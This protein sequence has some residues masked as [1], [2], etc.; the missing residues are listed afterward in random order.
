[1]TQARPAAPG[2]PDRLPSAPGRSTRPAAWAALLVAGLWLGVVA[3]AWLEPDPRH[4]KLAGAATALAAAALG[5]GMALF[6]AAGWR[7]PAWPRSRWAGRAVV[8]LAVGAL[9]GGIWAFGHRHLGGFDHS[10]LIDVAWRVAS[11]QRPGVDFPST[12]PIGFVLAAGHAFQI[13]GVTWS[14][15]IG[16]QALF[17][18]GTFLWLLWLLRRAGSG[19]GES[20]ALALAVEASTNVVTSYWWY[21]PA[22][23]TAGAL[24]FASAAAFWREPRARPV[25][26]SYVAS[27]LLLAAMKPNVAAALIVAVTL[28]LLSSRVHRLRAVTLSAAALALFAGWLALERNSLPGVLRGYLSVST[29][30]F[31]LQQ[32]LQDLTPSE[33]HAAVALLVATLVPWF[34]RVLA[35][36]R[37]GHARWLAVA[38][39]SAGLLGFVTNGEHKLVDVPLLLLSLWWHGRCDGDPG[40]GG[41]ARGGAALRWWRPL[42]LGLAGVLIA[43]GF[44]VGALR[45]RVSAIGPKSFFEP[46]VSKTALVSPF[47]DGLRGG[48]ILVEVER[49]VAIAV[50]TLRPGRPFFGP[51]MQW[52]YAAFGFESPRGQPPWWHPGVTYAEGSPEENAYV[53]RWVEARH[54]VLVFLRGDRTFLPPRLLWEEAHHYVELTGFQL[55]EVLVPAHR[56]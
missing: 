30:G 34:P 27:L 39:A 48:P 15:L 16:L 53:E 55:I 45:H 31:T 12:T 18:A 24:F 8:A 22:T 7:R 35:W 46:R 21:N 1:M 11:G 25:L 43:A 49:E 36:T 37:D 32:F 40:E 19:T 56:G 20:L 29:R 33:K 42:V 54:D 50:Q 2:G 6:A 3:L 51:R 5:A 41:A 52:G 9:A 28:V 14:A 10:A 23:T 4:F 47:F 44:G 17:A 13:F 38:A 26:A